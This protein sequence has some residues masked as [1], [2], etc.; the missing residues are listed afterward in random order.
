MSASRHVSSKKKKEETPPSHNSVMFCCITGSAS[1]T[2]GQLLTR[3][4]ICR[5][6]ASHFDG[7]S[8]P[9]RTLVITCTVFVYWGLFRATVALRNYVENNKTAAVITVICKLQEAA[10]FPFERQVR[11]VPRPKNKH[12]FVPFFQFSKLVP[13][14][15]D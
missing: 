1:R 10:H 2:P 15:L 11:S 5:L 8:S 3:G 6:A 12:T 4:V 13:I 14:I 7:L 9:P